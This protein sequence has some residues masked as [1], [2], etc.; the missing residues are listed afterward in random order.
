MIFFKKSS[1]YYFINTL[2]VLLKLQTVQQ[3]M[4]HKAL[5]D[6]VQTLL[7]VCL[8]YIEFRWSLVK[9][10]LKSFSFLSLPYAWQIATQLSESML[11]D[12][13][14]NNINYSESKQRD[15]KGRQDNC[16]FN[17]FVKKLENRRWVCTVVVTRG[18]SAPIQS[19]ILLSGALKDWKRKRRR[20]EGGS[21]DEDCG[22]G[23]VI[24]S[25]RAHE[26][27]GG[28]QKPAQNHAAAKSIKVCLTVIKDDFCRFCMKTLQFALILNPH[29]LKYPQT[30]DGT[31]MVVSDFE[32]Q[33]PRT[34][35][36]VLLW[37][38]PLITIFL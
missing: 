18:A 5:L 24:Y 10:R 25:H 7:I 1:F 12:V 35:Y 33:P 20:S 8:Y 38:A 23:G 36:M 27:Y 31:L 34:Y 14:K 11:C 15:L 26:C 3:T 6:S 37:R 22:I 2:I 21:R 17:F 28:R 4:N 13:E 30:H 32:D 16:F 9:C 19:F 29:S